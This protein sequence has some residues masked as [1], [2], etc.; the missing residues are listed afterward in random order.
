[1]QFTLH[2]TFIFLVLQVE[3]SS[4]PATGNGQ[5]TDQSYTAKVA[6][7]REVSE[8][9]LQHAFIQ[10]CPAEVG[11]SALTLNGDLTFRNPY[12]YLPVSYV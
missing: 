8:S 11:T 5:D 4:F 10:V 3:R 6:A 7:R 2:L 1:M 9:G 12:G